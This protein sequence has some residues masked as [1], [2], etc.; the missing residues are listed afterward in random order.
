VPVRIGAGGAE[1]VVKLK[2]TAAEK[3]M[4]KASEAAV[5]DVVSVL[6]LT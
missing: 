4:L 2:L 1:A 5:R 6:T 3:K